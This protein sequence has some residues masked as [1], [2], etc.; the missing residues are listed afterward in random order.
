[1]GDTGQT[2][3]IEAAL[4]WMAV[5][6]DGSGSESER[7]EFAAWL[8]MDAAH[9]DAWQ[10]AE[11]L[12]SGLAVIAPDAAAPK[13]ANTHSATVIPIAKASRA[14][15]MSRR[16]WLGAAASLAAVAIGG[17]VATQPALRA[18]HRT[19]TAEHRTVRLADGSKVE[20]GSTTTLSVA[21]SGDRRHVTLHEG[22]AFFE[23][24][25]DPARPFIVTAGNG[26][27]TALGTAFNIKRRDSAS[28][29]TVTE[30][31]VSVA[32][33]G[34]HGAPLTL[35]TGQQ[36]RYDRA[37]GT[38]RTV[39]PDH[40]QAWRRG[41]L[42]FEDS[43]LSEVVADLERH[44]Q[45]WIIIADDRIRNI[46]VT[47]VFDSRRADAALDAIS[48]TLPVRLTRIGGVVAVLSAS[49]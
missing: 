3:H 49:D 7:Q 9:R 18:D 12:W 45:G 41:R 26:T 32:V 17:Y 44:R 19:G 27:V 43:P 37:F 1:M 35:N 33:S 42:I 13:R 47:A 34:S 8:A 40:V 46:T 28:V 10:Q 4:H 20:L 5:L 16:A 29:V 48:D 15:L 38:V 36:V 22:E 25:A 23:V 6:H 21:F 14:P 2:P 11:D 30:H 24:A 39:N 31:A